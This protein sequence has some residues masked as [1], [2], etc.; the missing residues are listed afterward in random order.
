MKITRRRVYIASGL[1]VVALL[2]ALSL[3]SEPVSVD[4]AVVDRGPLAVTVD[5]DGETRVRERYVI[6][7]PVTGRMVRLEC[8]AGDSVEAGQILAR[9][10]PLP[11]D[12]R[13]RAEAAGRLQAAEAAHAAALARV[14][15]TTALWQDAVSARRRMEQVEAEL[16]GTYSARRMDEARTA[17]RAAELEVE[18]AT[19]AADAAGHQVE[20]ARATL[21]GSEGR[22]E[23]EPTLIRAPVDGRVLRI[24]EEC[25][26]AVTA[27][28]PIL[29][30]GDP[31]D[32][33]VVVDVLS[34]DASR[35][36]EG[37]PVHLT[38][39]PEAD[40]LRGVIRRIDPSAFTKLS[41]LGVEEQRVDV[42]V[43][44][45]GDVPLGDRYRVEAS[46]VVWEAENVV[47]VPTSALFRMEDGWGVFVVQDE[48]AGVR[49]V[50]I[51]QRGRR[52]A[53]VLSGLTPGDVVVLYPSGDVEDGV[54]V[55]PTG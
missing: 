15:Q 16:P 1:A 32:L 55:E 54:R 42:T 17:E 40:T 33:E 31:S 7:S 37:A 27:G 21:L 25:E 11:L 22:G 3:R 46:L 24:Y 53:E 45:D 35:L 26:R 4:T 6:S 9:V 48:R 43:A 38:A 19:Q 23:G 47:R 14:E 20:S 51:G 18:Q 10:F 28:S 2:V 52:Q 49:A 36:R 50:E 44:L 41:P 29:E 39:S 12:T 30:I 13:G 8:E 5:E 34:E